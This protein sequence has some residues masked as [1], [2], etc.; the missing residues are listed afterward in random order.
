[1]A[2]KCYIGID[3]GIDGGLSI[4]DENKELLCCEPMPTVE[5]FINKKTRRKYNLQE[6]NEIIETW[7]KENQVSMAGMERLRPIPKQS[8]QTGFSLGGGSMLFKELFTIL[9]F[10]FVEIE[11]H[12]WQKDIFNSLGVQYNK[13]NLKQASIQAAKQLFPAADFKPTERARKDS[14]GMTDSCLIA[15]YLRRHFQ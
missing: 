4:I 12:V 7:G 9:N 2:K 15:E 10:P 11:P 14:D 1:M 6:I 8:S 3:I 13:K 5:V